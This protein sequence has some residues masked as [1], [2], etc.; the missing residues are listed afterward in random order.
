MGSLSK[1]G[2]S[3]EEITDVF[4]TH[5]HFDH[6]GGA[7]KYDKNGKLVPTFPN[8]KYWTNQ[9]HWGW[10]VNPNP[11]E[12]ASFLS[13]NILP[14]ESAGVLQFIDFQKDSLEWL[15]GLHVHFAHGH[16]EALM[17]LEIRTD[18]QTCFYAADLMPSSFH[19]GMPY[20]MAYDVRPL[21]T[22]EEKEW[23]F[24][25]CLEKDWTLIFEHDPMGAFGKLERNEK[26]RV[27]L[28][29]KW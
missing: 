10:A 9:R 13:E 5:L 16:T 15:P 12:K 19:I 7:V 29:E 11:R 3:P 26:G 28:K 17:A 21:K 14:L 6:V 22:L 1:N 23:L 25:N 4:L 18:E 20:V 27:A 8:A 2:I 24:S